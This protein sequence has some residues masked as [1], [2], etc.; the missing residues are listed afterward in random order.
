MYRGRWSLHPNK[1]G[2]RDQI[3][4]TKLKYPIL[5][6]LEPELLRGAS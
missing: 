2:L 4:D 1:N 6:Y 5:W 3:L